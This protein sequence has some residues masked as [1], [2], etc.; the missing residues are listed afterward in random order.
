MAAEGKRLIRK[1]CVPNRKTKA[2]PSG[3]WSVDNAPVDWQT[4]LQY[5]KQDVVAE[6][7]NYNKMIG[8]GSMPAIEWDMWHLDQLI[9]LTGLT[10][11]T[12]LVD[13]AM[14]IDAKTQKLL[15]LQF[16]KLTGLDN[17]NS[18]QQLVPWLNERGYPYDNV[19][20]DTVEKFLKR[21]DID[22]D[23]PVM[24]ALRLRQS[25]SKTSNKK[26]QT[27]AN[28]APY[29]TL[30]GI[31]QYGGA[32]RTRRWAGR[33]FQPQNLPRG[34]F[35]TPEQMSAAIELTKTRDPEILAALYGVDRIADVLSSLIRNVVIPSSQGRKLT[36]ADLSSIETV[37][38]WWAA[39]ASSQLE[40]VRQGVDAYKDYGV[41]LLEKPYDQITKAERNYC[42]PAVLGCC[43]RLGGP[44]LRA[45]AE[46][47]G[48]VMT[49]EE[50]YRAVD[51][52]RNA[53]PE[54]VDLWAKLENAFA[55]CLETKETVTIDGRFRF[56]A[57]A[58]CIFI[59]LPSDRSLCYISP[60]VEVMPLVYEDRHTGETV[61]KMQPT[62]TYMG[63]DQVTRKWSRQ[64]THG[65]K[66]LENLIQA[67]ARDVLR[68]GMLHLSKQQ[69]YGDDFW[70]VGHV[71]DEI[72][73]DTPDDPKYT[74]L[75]QDAMTRSSQW[76]CPEAPLGSS[77][78]QA[79]FYMKD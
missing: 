2:N 25:T 17:P 46:A 65:G 72:I 10:I 68:D 5:N 16:A 75:L 63:V 15:S 47:M 39:G 11:D 27:L 71:H 20:K 64:S 33:L 48:V 74:A 24:V 6:R 9:N 55:R 51:I 40:K 13:A 59:D 26:Y 44:G 8:Y 60:K 21:S 49:R 31:F 62:L 32:Q 54:V 53:N 43:Y 66:L 22:A 18:Q 3:W 36:V 70:I 7:A 14:T 77:A 37:M 30:R 76:W 52:Y 38:T 1:F 79:D 45:Y 35:K 57:K 61:K 56:R 4:F 34:I 58:P 28:A 73:M 23:S 19:R 12:D 69:G 29:G 41:S 78:F 50:A 67:I 42:K